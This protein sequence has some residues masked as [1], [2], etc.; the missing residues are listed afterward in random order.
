LKHTFADAF[1]G[2]ANHAPAAQDNYFYSI[3]SYTASP[4][5]AHGNNFASFYPTTPM[6]FDLVAIEGMYGQRAFNTGNTTYTFNDGVKYW[7][8]INDTGG[9]DRIVYHGA[10][11][12]TID[13]NPGTFSSLSEAIAFHR[14]NGTTVTSKATVTIGP[15]VVI[16]D[17]TGGNG[18]DTLIGNSANNILSGGSGNDTVIGSG[19]YDYLMGGAGND[20]LYGNVG[21]DKLIGG[22]GSDHFYFNA[23]LN[24]TTNR[25]TVID[26]NV[27]QDSLHLENAIFTR[28]AV[29][30]HLNPAF[31]RAAAH[32]LDHNDYIVYNR[33]TGGLFYDPNGNGAGGEIQFA[34]FSNKPV[35]TASEFAVF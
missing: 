32:A 21:S 15:N 11:N 13:L 25:D 22:A 35:L 6:Y 17:A 12:S 31:F 28:L 34:L 9:R 7:Q 14:P 10:E 19:G 20:R 4:W 23:A 18:N 24:A 16:E 8:A 26:Y 30:A 29:A 3:M 2:P 33:A 27:A 1:N 5:S